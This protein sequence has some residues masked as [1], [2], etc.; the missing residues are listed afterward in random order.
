MKIQPS[1]YMKKCLRICFDAQVASML[2]TY[3]CIV[4]FEKGT[5]V[6]RVG[7]VVSSFYFIIYGIV[8]GYYIDDEGHE[9]TKCFEAENCF[10]GSE[11]YRTNQS[12]SSGYVTW[13]NTESEH[14][15]I[16]AKSGE[17]NV[18][19]LGD[20]TNAEVST[21]SGDIGISY[22]TPPQNLS[23]KISSGSDD[24]SV[25][26]EDAS[27]TMETSACKQGKI[28]DGTYSLTVN[29]DSG[30]VVIH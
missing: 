5:H 21:S 7:E 1:D 16:T 3:A 10:F 23:F 24:V 17:V 13:K 4:T 8:R 29:S 12:A 27:Y 28:G 22:E 20:Q 14:I 11:C 30:T 25:R 19:G 18:S 2:D 15:S 9:V 26:L 6:I